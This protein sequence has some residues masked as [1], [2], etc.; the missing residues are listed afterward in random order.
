M[1]FGY[2][3]KVGLLL[4]DLYM[5]VNGFVFLSK[6]FRESNKKKDFTYLS[7]NL[8]RIIFLKH[9]STYVLEFSDYFPSIKV[10]LGLLRIGIK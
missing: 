6:R 9:C 10:N 2:F 1:T 8:D 3:C 7:I 4:L 5:F